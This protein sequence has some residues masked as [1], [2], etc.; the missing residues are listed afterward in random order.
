MDYKKIYANLT[1]PNNRIK[2]KGDGLELHHIIPRHAGGSDKTSNLVL[3]THREH[4]KAHKLLFKIYGNIED[5]YA[6]LL[7]SGQTTKA[8]KLSQVK[9]G[10]V[11]GQINSK[12]GHMT[13]IQKLGASKGG[14]ATMAKNPGLASKMAKISIKNGA[15]LKGGA[16]A[17]K[18]CSKPIKC[19]N[20]KI[21]RSRRLASTELG[22]NPAG[23]W[24]NLTGKTSQCGGYTFK[25]V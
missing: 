10:M 20:G 2:A 12:S 14:L 17:A 3:L 19:S 4:V 9:G 1:K 15:H 18:V 5:Q 24:L 7:M 6:Y 11:Q 21:Y 8:R 25:Y 13:S 22:L 23:I 16:G